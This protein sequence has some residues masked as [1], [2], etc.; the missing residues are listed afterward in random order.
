MTGPLVD[1]TV[2]VHSAARPIARAVSSIIE[3]TIAPVRVNVIAHNMDQATI[4]ANLGIYA[5]DPR[6]RLLS[7]TDGISS[8]AGPMNFGFANS[9]APFLSLLGSDDEFEPGAIDSWLALQ[10]RTDAEVV[11]PRIR[12][13]TGRAD[14]YP[15]VRWGRRTQ[16]L[17]GV[18]DRLAY[19]SAPLGLIGRERF[20]ELRLTEGLLSGED[21]AYSLTLWFTARNITYDLAGPAYIINDDAGDRVTYAPRPIAQDFA[22]LDAITTL[23]WFAQANQ[24]IKTTIILKLLRIHLF[25][26]I[27]ARISTPAELSANRAEL[28]ELFERIVSIAP[29]ARHYLSRA[30]R[31][32]FDLLLDERSTPENLRQALAARHQYLTLPTIV[33]QNPLR[34]MHR[35]APFR[36]LFAGYRIQREVS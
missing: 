32:V 25:D 28:S 12:L 23:P 30:D 10:R 5:E 14:P 21:L 31:A 24:G 20:G 34:M 16:D 13:A 35:Q 19:R 8:P 15:P 36:T 3:H 27:A 26:A 17:D 29:N 22:F 2:A 33:T 4:Q 6:V 11:L 18:K 9:T 1:V 7:F